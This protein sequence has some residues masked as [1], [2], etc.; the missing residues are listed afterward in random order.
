MLYPLPSP[1]PCARTLGAAG[2]TKRHR[3][4]H[5]GSHAGGGYHRTAGSAVIGWVSCVPKN[6]WRLCQR[7]RLVGKAESAVR[8]QAVALLS[9]GSS[10]PW[11]HLLWRKPRNLHNCPGPEA[12]G[13][14][15]A[16]SPKPRRQWVALPLGPAPSVKQWRFHWLSSMAL[17]S[18]EPSLWSLQHS[19]PVLPCFWGL[20]AGVH[21]RYFQLELEWNNQYCSGSPK[22]YTC[23]MRHCGQSHPCPTPFSSHFLLYLL[24]GHTLLPAMAVASKPQRTGAGRNC[25][26]P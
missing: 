4:A 26:V 22:G 1:N 8:S 11:T 2:T 12:H 15:W 9:G 16:T 21:A 3:D 20:G 23:V 7:R 17:P 18:H 14:G 19:D 5:L 25:K 24:V 6:G 10:C 13:S